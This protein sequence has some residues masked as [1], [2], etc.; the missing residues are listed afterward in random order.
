MSPD[1]YSTRWRVLAFTRIF[2]VTWDVALVFGQRRDPPAAL[3]LGAYDVRGCVAD[4]N[5]P[6][7]LRLRDRVAAVLNLA[8]LIPA[9]RFSAPA[10]CWVR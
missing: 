10:P 5:R 7:W 6:V 3:D 1:T 2:R 9:G 8:D 4:N